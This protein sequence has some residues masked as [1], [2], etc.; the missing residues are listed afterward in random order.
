MF[1]NKV[2]FSFFSSLLVILSELNRKL[3][4]VDFYSPNKDVKTISLIDLKNQLKEQLRKLPH[5]Y[6]KN[7][8]YSEHISFFKPITFL[9]S[10]RKVVNNCLQSTIFLPI[11]LQ[12]EL[13]VAPC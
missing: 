11:I 7:M 10:L 6:S 13:D 3:E 2:T 5:P 12:S 8:K 4:S 1:L 9:S